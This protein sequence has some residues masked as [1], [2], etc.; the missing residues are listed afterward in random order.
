MR[1]QVFRDDGDDGA[2]LV[3]GPPAAMYAAPHVCWRL[4]EMQRTCTDTS[5]RLPSEH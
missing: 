5:T 4:G 3:A 1:I 2:F